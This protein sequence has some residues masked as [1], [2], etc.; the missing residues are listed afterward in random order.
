MGQIEVNI[1][2]THFFWFLPFKIVFSAF[3]YN[4]PVNV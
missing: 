3:Y 1:V 4:Y 2:I